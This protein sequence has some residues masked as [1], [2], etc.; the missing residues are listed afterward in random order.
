M[1]E[2]DGISALKEIKKMDLETE[3]IMCSA[4]GQHA[5]VLEAVSLGAK[6]YL[7]KPF[8]EARVLEVVKSVIG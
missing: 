3:V 6:N 2:M 1:P 5:V 4:M 8:N 7:V